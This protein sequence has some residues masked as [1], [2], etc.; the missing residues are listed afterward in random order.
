MPKYGLLC[1]FIWSSFHVA[2][3][4]LAFAIYTLIGSWNST[5]VILMI[6]LLLSGY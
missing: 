3:L 5:C 1:R 2:K 4:C 6:A